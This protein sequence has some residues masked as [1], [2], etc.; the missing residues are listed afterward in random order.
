MRNL[1]LKHK[2]RIDDPLDLTIMEIQQA[3]S[4]NRLQE[5]VT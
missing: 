4:L 2:K 3:A 1:S 5:V